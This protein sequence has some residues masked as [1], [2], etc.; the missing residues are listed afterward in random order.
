MSDFNYNEFYNLSKQIYSDNNYE[1]EARYRTAINRAYYSAFL[2]VYHHYILQGFKIKNKNRI[3]KEIR[4]KLQSELPKI[5]NKL[6][7]LHNQ[8]RV[9]SD[10]YLEEG[11]DSFQ[12]R[13]A[14]TLTDLILTLIKNK[15]S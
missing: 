5:G 8:Y 11:I 4:E 7:K 15:L 14:F 1:E 12:V 10:Y 13:Q 6:E 2:A 9:P 3:H